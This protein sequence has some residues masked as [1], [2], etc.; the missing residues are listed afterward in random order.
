L[1]AQTSEARSN[2]WKYKNVRGTAIL[3]TTCQA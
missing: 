2:T 3:E 1:A